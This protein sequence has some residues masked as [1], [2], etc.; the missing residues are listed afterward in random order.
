MPGL[1]L[2][3]GAPAPVVFRALL[4][5]VAPKRLP[6]AAPRQVSAAGIVSRSFEMADGSEII[7]RAGAGG[8][9]SAEN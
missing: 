1:G 6:S 5:S 7:F 9:H 2:P 4:G 3:A 8:L